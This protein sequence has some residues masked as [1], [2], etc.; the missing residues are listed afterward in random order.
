MGINKKNLK[1]ARKHIANVSASMIRME[2]YRDRPPTKE[3]PECDTVG[4]IVGHATILDAYNVIKNFTNKYGGIDFTL[5]S[6]D[7]FGI[8][9][10][11][12]LWN[13]LFG[14]QHLNIKD[15]HLHRMD[16]ILAGNKAPDIIYEVDYYYDC[17]LHYDDGYF[18]PKGWEI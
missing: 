13:Y 15:Y 3:K 10:K 14:Q 9:R 12:Y 7:F 8:D 17:I 6:K 16:Y 1:R 11:S 2:N 4:C 18:T 5:W